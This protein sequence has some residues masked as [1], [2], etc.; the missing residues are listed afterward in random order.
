MECTLHSLLLGIIRI[1]GSFNTLLTATAVGCGGIIGA[2]LTGEGAIMAGAD[3]TIHGT[4]DLAGADGMTHGNPAITAGAAGAVTTAGAI[5]TMEDITVGV[6]TM[7]AIMAVTTVITTTVVIT[8]RITELIAK[9]T[10]AQS[11]RT[12]I[13]FPV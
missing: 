7:A 6:D 5:L 2:T 10:D 4:P 9:R 12:D 3:G 8:Q 1:G 11:V 13:L